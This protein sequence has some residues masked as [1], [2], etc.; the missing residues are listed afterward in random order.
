VKA[1]RPGQPPIVAP[2]GRPTSELRALAN[3]TCKFRGTFV[4]YSGSLLN[5][6]RT[7]ST[8]GRQQMTIKTSAL[9]GLS[10]PMLAGLLFCSAQAYAAPPAC[11]TLPAPFPCGQGTHQVCTKTVKC[12][13]NKPGTV[14][15]LSST[16][17]QAKCVKDIVL[18]NPGTT[19]APAKKPQQLNPQPEPP[20]QK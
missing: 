2:R 17:T 1:P 13:G 7:N 14:P 10:G 3:T 5:G 11:N 12:Y 9:L 18:K 8:T 19:A 16:C 6:G 15:Q 20:G 4:T